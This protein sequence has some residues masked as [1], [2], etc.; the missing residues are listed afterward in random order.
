MTKKILV[1]SSLNLSGS[2]WPDGAQLHQV[3]LAAVALSFAAL[4]GCDRVPGQALD[5]K[6]PDG[7]IEARDG[8]CCGCLCRDPSWSCSVDTCIDPSGQALTTAAEAGFFEL[9]GGEY[10][11]EGETRVSPIHRIWYSFQP[12]SFSPEDKPLAVF[13][14]GGPGSATSSFLFS[15]NTSAF[16]LDPGATGSAQIAANPNSWTRFA[17]LLF[18]DP[19]AC[20]FSYPIALDSGDKPSIQIDLDRDAASVVRVIVRFL[21]RHA[22]LQ[23]N[24]VILVG[25]SYGGTRAE[26]MLKHLLNYQSLASPD[27]PYRDPGLYDDLIH[28]FA[29][30]FPQEDPRQLPAS[31][32]ARQFSHQVLIQPF[33]GGM[34]QFE[35]NTPDTSMCRPD[36][37]FDGYQCDEPANWT[38]SNSLVVAG[39]LTNLAT[40]KQMLGVDPKTIDWLHA[41][42]R[43]TAYGRGTGTMVDTPEL[44]AAFGSLGPDDRYLLLFNPGVVSGS[45]T[46][47]WWSTDPTLGA[48]FLTDL[49]YVR[50][51][52]TNAKYDTVVWTPAIPGALAVY[53]GLV[54]GVSIDAAARA[55]VARTGWIE[56]SYA[57]DIGV[58]PVV[59]EIRFP[60]YEN[61]GHAVPVRA[62]AELLADVMEWYASGAVN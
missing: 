16:T 39:R 52:I 3:F 31:Q 13:F 62:S 4:P 11:S 58:D 34:F 30:T 18:I 14:N 44:N 32:V 21:D 20:G 40:L 35:L 28:H 7:S 2:T 5:V 46:R 33:V 57:Q 9:P 55:G 47:R 29:A 36:Q 45:G 50:T 61:A 60:Y 37:D 41:S 56:V 19:P 49:I 15:D 17:N 8:S 12:A 48:N 26:L 51:F 24:P 59:R 42:A 1:R 54:A 6:S 23:R 43:T 25:E 22:A 38:N 27:A 53:T 10:V